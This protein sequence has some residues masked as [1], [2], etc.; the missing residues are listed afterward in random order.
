MVG[1]RGALPNVHITIILYNKIVR[2]GDGN[3]KVHKTVNAVYVMSP[4]E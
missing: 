1:W 3:K 4:Y 2:N